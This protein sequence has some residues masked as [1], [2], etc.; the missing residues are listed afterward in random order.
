MTEVTFLAPIGQ[1]LEVLNPKMA[2]Q[3]QASP[4]FHAFPV[5]FELLRPAVEANGCVA[6]PQKKPRGGRPGPPYWSRN[7]A[8]RG[9]NGL[10]CREGTRDGTTIRS[11]VSRIMANFVCDY[12]LKLQ[13]IAFMINGPRGECVIDVNHMISHAHPRDAF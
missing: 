5:G 12:P 9:T 8:D 4:V 6:G 11:M 10:T 7:K 13:S 3:S 2:I 1:L